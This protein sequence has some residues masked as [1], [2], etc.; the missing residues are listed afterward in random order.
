MRTLRHNVRTALVC[1]I[2]TLALA[3]CKSCASSVIPPEALAHHD[4]AI[5]YLNQGQCLE[6][7]ERCRLSLE[8]APNFAHPHNCLGLI[9]LHCRNNLDEAAKHFKRAISANSDFVEAH[10]NLGVTFFRRNPPMYDEACEQYLAAIEINPGF[11]DGR[12]NLGL[13]LMRRG[14]I[15]GSKKKIDERTKLFRKARSHLIRLTELNPD[16]F[17]ARDY[18]GFMDMMEE[19]YDAAERNFRRCLEIDEEN[20]ICSFHLGQTY[21]N[22]A[23]CNDAIQFFVSSLRSGDKAIAPESRRQLANAYEQ[24]AKTDGAI[25]AFLETIKNDPGNP[26]HHYDLGN[27]YFDKGLFDRAVNEWEN[28][29]KL[30]SMYCMAYF[31]LSQQANKNLDSATTIRRCQDFVHCAKEQNRNEAVP[32]WSPETSECKELIR[33]LEL[34]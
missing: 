9:E 28:T 19:R 5:Q 26:T 11:L 8:Y 18:L 2:I 25:K 3:G 29:I 4:I 21:L 22:T 23:R 1:L 10:N 15:A 24:C 31:K 32:R 33:K 7:E 6:A 30:D 14:V 12:E 20:P 17:N 13:C 27:I 16:N 34:E